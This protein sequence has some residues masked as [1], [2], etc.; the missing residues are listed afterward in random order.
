LP[1]VGAFFLHEAL[2]ALEGRGFAAGRVSVALPPRDRK[3]R[4]ED[5]L[6]ARLDEWP[7]DRRRYRVIRAD[8]RD[9]AEDGLVDLLITPAWGFFLRNCR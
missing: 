4:A 3:D 5:E 2:E 8:L 1:D 6:S 9:P 7:G